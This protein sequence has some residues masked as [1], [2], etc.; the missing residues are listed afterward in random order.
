MFTSPFPDVDI[1]NVSIYDEAERRAVTPLTAAEEL[2]AER[3][4]AGA[5]APEGA[6]AG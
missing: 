1:P 3:L 5:A 4:S 2:A 6:L